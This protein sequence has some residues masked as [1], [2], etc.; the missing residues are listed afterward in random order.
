MLYN[1]GDILVCKTAVDTRCLEMTNHSFIIMPEDRYIV[2]DKDDY[3]EEH[4]CHWYEL[5]SE[6]DKSIVLNAWNDEGH[7][8]I[9]DKFERINNG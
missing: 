7:M 8:I 4:H 6:K 1:I 2:T 3:P 9:D 5:T